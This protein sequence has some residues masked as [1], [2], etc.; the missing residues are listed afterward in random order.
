MK[1]NYL[2]G[3]D[4]ADAKRLRK[5]AKILE[6]FGT[7]VQYSFFHCFIS[8]GQKKRMRTLIAGEIHDGQDQIIILPVTERQLKEIEVL[9]FRINLRAEGIFIV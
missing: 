6:G 2:I 1:H 8:E 7:R 9:G 4:I 3:Y 5:V